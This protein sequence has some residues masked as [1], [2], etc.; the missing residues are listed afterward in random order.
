VSAGHVHALYRHG[1]G[2]LH[3]LAP[4]V[5]LAATLLFVAAVVATP[6]TAMWA[7][8]VHAIV[9]VILMSIGR[10]PPGF[11]V[12]RMLVEIPFLLFAFALPFIGRGER[13]DVLGLTLSR[14]GL[15][16]AWNIVAKATLGIAAS[17]VLAGTTQVPDLLKGFQRLRFPRAITSI[18]G[19]MVRYLDVVI[20]EL[21]RMRIALQSRGYRPRRIGQTRPL[22]AAAGTLFIR[23]YERGERVYLAMLSRGYT[24]SMP[25]LGTD[26][27]DA[28]Q[29]AVAAVAPIVA[30]GVAVGAWVVA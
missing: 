15:W 7:F 4:E 13:I 14:D 11:V 21:N 1:T 19:F 6:R 2:P 26:R 5:K 8:A 20:G 17:I 23:S 24:G 30:A 29:W 27:A 25:D 28:A 16:G 3:R 18:M 22:A 9:L 10:L 12:K